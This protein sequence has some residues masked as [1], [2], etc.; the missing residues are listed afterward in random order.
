MSLDTSDGE[1]CKDIGW[2]GAEKV[3]SSQSGRVE[4]PSS[5]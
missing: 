2:E 3:R 1:G 4:M 5:L